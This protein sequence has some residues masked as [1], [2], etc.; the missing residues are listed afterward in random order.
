MVGCSRFCLQG[1]EKLEDA[2]EASFARFVCG[3]LAGTVAKLAT[4]P[5]DVA[6]KRYQVSL[7]AVPEMFFAVHICGIPP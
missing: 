2:P 7:Q 5:L 6:K 1:P 4:H 3:L